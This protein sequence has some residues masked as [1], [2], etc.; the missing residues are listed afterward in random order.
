[1][2]SG[3]TT[4]LSSVKKP[5]TLLLMSPYTSIKEAARQLL[6]WVSFLSFIVEEKFRNIDT[7]KNAKCPVFFLH[8]KVDTLIPFSHSQKLALAAPTESHL[9][10]PAKMDHNE[11]YLEEDLVN[12]FS[13]FLEKI[14]GNTQHRANQRADSKDKNFKRLNLGMAED[15]EIPFENDLVTPRSAREVNVMQFKSSCQRNFGMQTQRVNMNSRRRSRNGKHRKTTQSHHYEVRYNFNL[16]THCSKVDGS[17]VDYML[18]SETGNFIIYFDKDLYEP[19]SLIV[20]AEQN[21]VSK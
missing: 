6:G 8:G 10:L 3:P 16:K 2:G 9:H 20:K 19:P 11:F 13:R 12:P 18:D 21:Q 5:H 17:F 4:Y 15:N 7:I 1:M 14:S